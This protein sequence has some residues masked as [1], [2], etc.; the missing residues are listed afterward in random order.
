[1]KIIELKSNNIKKLKAVELKLDENKNVILVTGKNGQ[2]KTSV[3]DSIWYALGGKKA[4]QQKPIR[5]GEEKAEIEIDLDG[6]IVKRTFTESGSYLSVTNGE[7]SKYSNPQEFL[8]YV[9]GSLSFD[10]LEFSRLDN[11]KQVDELT[12]VVGL[13]LSPLDEKKKELTQ[14]RLLVGRQIKAM[15]TRLPESIQESQ[16][17]LK[18]NPKIPSMQELVSKFNDASAEVS[19]YERALKAI[20]EQE[21]YVKDARSAIVNLKKVKKPLHDLTAMKDEISNIQSLSEQIVS[22]RQVVEDADKIDKAKSEYDKL[23][24]VIAGIDKEKKDKLSKVK[25]PVSGLSWEEDGVLYNNI[26]YSQISAAEQLR[27]SMAIAMASNPKLK[28]IL[29]RD[30]SLLDS[31]NMKVIESMAKDKDWQVWIERV[32]NSGKV[33]IFMEDGEIKK[34]N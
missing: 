16:K 21:L 22:S 12:R 7:G 24:R 27:V 18:E 17:I 29:I 28:V 1:M 13:D 30:G 9:V 10:P 19:N 23:T 20:K 34:I 15:P 32:D 5:D 6:Y 2:G 3:L 26:P 8:D 11:K 31:D 33:G 25:M 4:A 14:D